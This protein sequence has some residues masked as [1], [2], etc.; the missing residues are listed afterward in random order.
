[1]AGT[2]APGSTEA[3]GEQPHPEPIGGRRE[4]HGNP[5]AKIKA[6]STESQGD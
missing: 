3:H 4:D 2:V 6:P 1:M 5:W